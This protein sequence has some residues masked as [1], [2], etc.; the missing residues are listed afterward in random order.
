MITGDNRRE[1]LT[2]H[3]SDVEF[4]SRR[5]NGLCFRREEKYYVGHRCKVEAECEEQIIEVEAVENLNIELSIN[6]FVGLTNLGTMKVKGKVKEEDVLVLID[7]G[8]TQN[9]ISEKLVT[10]L[11]FPIKATINY[12]VILRFGIAIKGKGVCGKI[13]VLIGE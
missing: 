11:N 5:K 10:D 9:F 12:V 1:G 8:A 7:Y 3:L 6:S 4:Q 2:K 13:E